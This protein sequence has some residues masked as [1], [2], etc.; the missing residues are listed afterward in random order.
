MIGQ[1]GTWGAYTA[2]PNGKKVCFALAKPSSS[3]T[4]PPSRPRD[5]ARIA[6]SGETLPDAVAYTVADNGVGFEM[7]YVDK[8]FGV[9]QR[10]HRAEDFEGTGIGL[11]LVK[12]IVERHGGAV[13]A[14]S[15]PGKGAEFTFTLPAR[16]PG[17]QGETT[18]G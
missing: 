18:R 8:L 7:A 1:F 13:V 17:A 9:F 10:L 11:A 15:E 16:K 5:P 2:T 4:N 6:V 12:R 14:R 3:K